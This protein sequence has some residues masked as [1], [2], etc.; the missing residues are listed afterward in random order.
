MSQASPSSPKIGL[1]LGSGGARGWA[2]IGVLR[3]L[4]DLG[5]HP[6]C[7]AGTS[8]GAIAAAL[9]ATKRL[10]TIESL[11]SELDW[12]RLAQLFF[13]VSLPRSGLI[14][15]KNFMRLLKDMIPAKTIADL[16]MPYAAIA[17]DIETEQEVVLTSGNLFEIIRASIGIPGIF[18]PTRLDGRILVDG[19]LVNPLPVSACRAMAADFV[20]AVDVNLRTPKKPRKTVTQPNSETVDP[21]VAKLIDSAI[22]F[23]PKLEDQKRAWIKRLAVPQRTLQHSL[24][25]FDVL[26]RTM[27]LVE[28]QITRHE[29]TLH[30]PDLLIQP[31]V[32]DILTL[33]FHRGP[34]AI[35]AGMHAV[36]ELLPQIKKV[37]DSQNKGVVVTSPSLKRTNKDVK[38]KTGTPSH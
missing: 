30:P 22:K 36:D 23:L 14:S 17:T 33:E 7:I 6:D 4:N 29:L 5:I 27:R 16:N 38:A 26:T 11:A 28:N 21:R 3:R 2:H 25:I 13:E 18:T 35:A 12:K 9:Y 20:I 10:D 8:I 19:G 34:E 24:S 37:L 32:G 1:V 15:G 31:A